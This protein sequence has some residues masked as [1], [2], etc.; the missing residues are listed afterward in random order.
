M[1]GSVLG[2]NAGSV[3][4]DN[5]HFGGHKGGALALACELLAA[6]M[7]GAPVQ[8]GPANS[9][10]IVNSMFSVL[11]DPE[12]LGTADDYARQLDAVTRWVLSENETGGG[13]KLP[14][15]PE[16]TARADRRANG[17]EIDAVT[18]AQITEVATKLGL[19]GPLF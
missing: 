7:V 11:V 13:V 4:G 14:G 6:A 19:E 3:L 18:I 17:I 15:D 10:A 9:T 2:D 8:D 5:Q 12:T 1:G 16:R